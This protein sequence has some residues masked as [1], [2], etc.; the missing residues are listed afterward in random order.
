MPIQWGPSVKKIAEV[1]IEGCAFCHE[2]APFSVFEQSYQVRLMFLVPLANFQSKRFLVCERCKH[3][4][5][6]EPSRAL[7]LIAESK[8]LPSHEAAAAM[9]NAMDEAATRWVSGGELGG[10][11]KTVADVLEHVG[12]KLKS[13]FPGAHVD[14]I[15]QRYLEW[16]KA[17]AS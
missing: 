1:G 4:W 16:C 12:G 17:A 8:M 2:P 14:A 7:G 6:L 9:W 11:C 3:S 13:Q 10:E 5:E 15:A